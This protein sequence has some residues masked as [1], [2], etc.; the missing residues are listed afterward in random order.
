MLQFN[1]IKKIVSAMQ[2][3]QFYFVYL[4]PTVD[5]TPN[6][7]QL[8]ISKMFREIYMSALTSLA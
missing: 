8:I 1:Y 4:T 3:L 2:Y 5:E 6:V 7:R